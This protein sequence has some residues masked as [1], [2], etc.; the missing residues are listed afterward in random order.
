MATAQKEQGLKKKKKKGLQGKQPI[1]LKSALS[2]T[3][4]VGFFGNS[5]IS[6]SR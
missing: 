5:H 1:N 4:T 2:R 6:S 3:G